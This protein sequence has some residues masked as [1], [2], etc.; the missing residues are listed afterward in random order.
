MNEST[1]ARAGLAVLRR[2][3]VGHR[4]ETAT[5]ETWDR[6]YGPSGPETLARRQN[7]VQFRAADLERLK[8]QLPPELVR[9]LEDQLLA[10][11]RANAADETR[12]RGEDEW[13]E[14]TQSEMA[15]ERL[16]AESLAGLK[17]LSDMRTGAGPQDYGREMPDDPA[18]ATTVPREPRLPAL[19]DAEV[20][21]LNPEL[22]SSRPPIDGPEFTDGIAGAG[23]KDKDRNDAPTSREKLAARIREIAKSIE[24]YQYGQAGAVAGGAGLGAAVAGRGRRLKG[25]LIGG[26][27]GGLAALGMEYRKRNS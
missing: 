27:L 25:A 6:V 15:S 13:R 8:K 4:A 12:L 16:S 2:L 5:R 23:K 26:G 7:S 24:P 3:T 10:E 18:D 17:R 19:S 20:Y 11:A 14:R 22:G 9:E 1:R 21:A